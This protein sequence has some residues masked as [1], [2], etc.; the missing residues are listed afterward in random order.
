MT[1][2]RSRLH[3]NHPKAKAVFHT[4]QHWTTAICC[5]EDSRFVSFKLILIAVSLP[6]CITG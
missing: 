4:H 5:L 6:C 2:W 1:F 3:L